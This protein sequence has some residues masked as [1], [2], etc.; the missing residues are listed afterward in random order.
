MESSV[1][2]NGEEKVE[3]S[4][5]PVIPATLEPGKSWLKGPCRGWEVS[6]TGKQIEAGAQETDLC[7]RLLAPPASQGLSRGTEM[8]PGTPLS[9]PHSSTVTMTFPLGLHRTSN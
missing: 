4:S 7:L 2:R 3:S 6:L 9:L 5:R 1:G 8:L